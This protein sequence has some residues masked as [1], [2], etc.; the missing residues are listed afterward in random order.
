MCSAQTHPAL[1]P[2][3]MKFQ[4]TVAHL[5]AHGLQRHGVEIVFGQSLPS[6]LHLAC[7]QSGIRQVGY[8]TEN[9]G[10]YMADG[11]ARVKGRAAVVTSQNGPAATL[12]VPSL[13]EALKASIPV[14]ALIQDVN[15]DQTD[16]NAFQEFDHVALFSSC[17][18][19]VRR[20]TEASRVED[21]LDQ[22]FINACSGR[23]GPAVLLLPADLLAQD[24]PSP[25]RRARMGQFPLDRTV[26]CAQSI[27]AAADVIRNARA[28]IVIAGGGVHVSGAALVLA[29]LQ[30][31][32]HLPVATTTMGKGCVDERHPLSVGVVG[33]FMGVNSATRWQRSLITD[34]DVVILVGNRSNQ[35]GTD[36]WTLYPK[37]A[38]YI[39][40]DID[41]AE[42]GR[43]YEALRLVGDARETLEALRE[44]LLRGDLSGR[45]LSRVD[46]QSRISRGR[47]AYEKESFAVRNATAK[48]VRPERIMEEINRRLDSE[49]IVVAD[50]S[51]SSTWVA[52]FLTSQHAGMRFI[53]PRGLA[54]LGWG[55]PM[56]MGAKLAHPQASVICVV[57]DGG[58]GHVWSELETA[59]REKIPLTLIVLS[60]G[61]L[62]FQKHA[63]NV[64]FGA[65]TSAVD[66]SDVDHAALARACGCN[67]IRVQDPA[68]IGPALSEA[69]SADRLTLIDVICD[70]DAFPPLTI[71]TSC[72]ETP[73]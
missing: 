46:L 32:V 1:H 29:R 41:S 50:A 28:P 62:G 2:T 8:R 42:V 15:R 18:K 60:N 45:A 59:V 34:A 47:D 26:A 37:S 6:L 13:A 19:W 22:A 44:A 31:D 55:L 65:H 56:A 27:Q 17:A 4:S 40:I 54:G 39:H 38:Q 16:R 11:Y 73:Q 7:A 21:Y 5:L 53:T 57:G 10:G 43:N 33:S 35:N 52:N 20:V 72:L 63:E 68:E 3:G 51:Y 69:A 30:E 36:S 48:P 49:T 58:F 9:A 71:F 12:L 64:K 14:V 66:F 24:A 70:P 67:G 25:N 23:P 61:I